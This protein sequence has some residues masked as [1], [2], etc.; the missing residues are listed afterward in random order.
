[1]GVNDDPHTGGVEVVR[2]VESTTFHPSPLRLAS[3]PRLALRL[4]LVGVSFAAAFT[5]I[6]FLTGGS[7]ATA[8]ERDAEGTA[9]QSSPAAP[10]TSLILPIIDRDAAPVAAVDQLVDNV[11]APVAATDASPVAAA[12]GVPVSAVAAAPLVAEVIAPVVEIAVAPALGGVPRAGIVPSAGVGP[13]ESALDAALTPFSDALTDAGVGSPLTELRAAPSG[14]DGF[15]T[16]SNAESVRLPSPLNSVFMLRSGG[17]PPPL[18]FGGPADA[19]AVPAVPAGQTNGNTGAGGG[20]SPCPSD[21][22]GT[23]A[24]PFLLGGRQVAPGDDSAPVS[25]AFEPGSTPG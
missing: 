22:P 15:S 14:S 3:R 6:G 19:P 21:L 9:S 13:I 12:M 8:S 18:P 1:M 5:V 24:P 17:F 11:A 7:T 16:T 4:C 10:I 25:P 2:R 20:G 23:S